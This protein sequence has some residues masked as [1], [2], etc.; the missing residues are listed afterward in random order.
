V[1]RLLA[2]FILVPFVELVLLLQ[3]A[4][5]TSISFTLGLIVVT[6]LVGTM[7]ARHQGWQT[8][9]SI[10]RQMQSG[11]LPTEPLL[12][13]AMIFFAGALLLTPGMLTDIFGLS[14]LLPFCRRFY[15]KQVSSWIRR[16]FQVQSFHYGPPGDRPEPDDDVVDS[17]VVDKQDRIDEDP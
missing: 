10:Q 12:D 1:L 6:G 8:M 14:L 2:L 15:R 13:A 11:K 3:L 16:N 9:Q 5:Y 4:K 17:Y 7:L